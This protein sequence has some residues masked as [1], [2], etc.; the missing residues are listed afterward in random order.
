MALA[1]AQALEEWPDGKCEA[2]ASRAQAI[3]DIVQEESGR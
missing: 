3:L 2:R 1:L